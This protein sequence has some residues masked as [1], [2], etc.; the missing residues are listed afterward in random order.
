MLVS[1]PIPTH[2]V[3]SVTI[4]KNAPVPAP[5]SMTQ[6]VGVMTYLGPNI[7]S[8]SVIFITQPVWEFGV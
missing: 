2:P 7:P 4:N 3:S 1:V 6:E 8:A 5:P